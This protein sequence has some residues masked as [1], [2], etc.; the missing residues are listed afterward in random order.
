MWLYFAKG[1]TARRIV[2]W[3]ERSRHLLG[4]FRAACRRSL[5]FAFFAHRNSR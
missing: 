5:K 3:E 2:G 4:Q 1:T